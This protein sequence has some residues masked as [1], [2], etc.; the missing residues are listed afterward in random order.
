MT[1]SKKQQKKGQIDFSDS[2]LIMSNVIG[3]LVIVDSTTGRKWEISEYGKTRPMM[4]GDIMNINA[5]QPAIF[6]QGWAI[7]LD[8]DI[9]EYLGYS[10]LYKSII[11]PKDMDNFLKLPENEIKDILRNAPNGMKQTIAKVVKEKIANKDPNFDSYAK[12]KF[13][14]DNLK[15][16]LT[17]DSA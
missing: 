4:I 11:K 14:E 16:K 7:I 8:E 3:T 10:E 2:C 12:I 6:E 15:I 13:F 1:R 5:D 9:V 17:S